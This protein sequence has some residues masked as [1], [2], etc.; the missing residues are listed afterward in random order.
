MTTYSE[1][2]LLQRLK[3]EMAEVQERLSKLEADTKKAPVKKAPIKSEKQ[4]E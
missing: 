4:G 1:M 2:L 3:E